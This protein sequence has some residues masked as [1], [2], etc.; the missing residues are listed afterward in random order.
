MVGDEVEGTAD[1]ESAAVYHRSGL[2]TYCPVLEF[3]RSIG[4]SDADIA[5]I[6]ERDKSDIEK[7]EQE[8]ITWNTDL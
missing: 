6:A 4:Q 7:K 1:W 5:D 8:I 2:R 3:Q